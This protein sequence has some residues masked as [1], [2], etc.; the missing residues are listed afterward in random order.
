MRIWCIKIG[1]VLVLHYKNMFDDY[2]YYVICLLFT[3][4]QT[5]WTSRFVDNLFLCLLLNWAFS[6]TLNVYKNSY[7]FDKRTYDISDT[8]KLLFL[9]IIDDSISVDSHSAVYHHVSELRRYS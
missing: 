2:V 1:I 3:L 9:E 4:W 8:N 5:S 7:S 6:R